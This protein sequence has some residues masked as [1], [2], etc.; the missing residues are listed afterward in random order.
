MRIAAFLAPAATAGL[1][2]I[3]AGPSWALSG[4]CYWSRLEQPTRDALLQGYQRLGPQ[5]LDRVPVSD[6]ELADIDAACGPGPEDLKDRLLS[7]TVLEH[8]SAAFLK[9]WL[10]WDDD[11]IQAAWARIDPEQAEQ[12][13]R[14]ADAVLARSAPS[15][16][17]LSRAVGEFL[18]Q[19]PDRQAPGVVDQ[20][21][22]YLTSRAIREAI[23]RRG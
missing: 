16:E 21:R 8:G 22:G 13:R 1:L 17:S 15:D 19:D 18:G 3:A 6:R 23:E 5:V 4:Q 20:V 10:R 7:A 2:L 11:A 14:Q 9:G 12:L